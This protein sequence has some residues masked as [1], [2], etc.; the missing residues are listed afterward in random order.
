[1]NDQTKQLYLKKR[2]YLLKSL[3]SLFGY[4]NQAEEMYELVWSKNVTPEI[5]DDLVKK[6][7]IA[8]E[9]VEDNNKKKKMLNIHK[10]LDNMHKLEKKDT[11]TETEKIEQ[12]LK[13]I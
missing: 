4:W 12:L 11:E 2:D 10:N 3:K 13:Q 1:M 6:L 9:K 5:I 8:A 7:K